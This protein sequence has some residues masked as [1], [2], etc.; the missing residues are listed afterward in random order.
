MLTIVF[1]AFL[2][3]NFFAI[4]DFGH[5]WNVHFAILRKSFYKK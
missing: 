1:S 4:F 3:E 2:H 5:F